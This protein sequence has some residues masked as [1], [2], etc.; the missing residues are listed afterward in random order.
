MNTAARIRLITAILLLTLSAAFVPSHARAAAYS[1]SAT[2][3]VFK[4]GNLI[5]P[6]AG[7]ENPD[8]F[9]F[10][11][12]DSRLDLKPLNWE[13]V[14]PL[15]PKTV[16][17]DVWERWSNPATGRDPGRP[18]TLGQNVT[19]NMAAYWEVNLS[20][21]S[22]EEL[23][24]YDLLFISHRQDFGFTA[25]DRE[26]LRKLVDAGGIVWIE[27]SG[28][29]R[30]VAGGEFFLPQLQ[31]AGTA[32]GAP[33]GPVVNAPHHP[34]LNTPYR[35][36]YDEIAS[37][38]DKNYG[39][40]HIHS[41]FNAN[42]PPDPSVLINIVGNSAAG[43]LPYI[44]GGSY[45]SGAV[46]A[47]SS[48]SGSDI[49]DYAG[50]TNPRGVGG[51]SGAYSGPN[52][53]AA[54]SED[55]KFVYNLVAW[56][57]A[58]N[59]ERRNARR[60]ASSFDAVGAPLVERFTF[61]SP[62]VPP[63][64]RVVSPSA[65]LIVKEVAFVT[66]VVA[67]K[68]V[69][70]AYD[71]QPSRDLDNDGNPDEGVPDLA[72]G[73]PYDEIWRAELTSKSPGGS[74]YP[75]APSF[76]TLGTAEG[77]DE[78]VFVT[79]D[80]G[81][82]VAFRAFPNNNGILLP[83]NALAYTNPPSGG[84]G[85][86]Y[87]QSIAPSPVFYEGRIYVSQPDGIVR[88]VEASTGKTLH[89]T[90]ET[91]QPYAVTGSP[92]VGFTRYQPPLAGPRS[93]GAANNAL[94]LVLY[95]P[96]R[97]TG[98]GSG[99]RI[100]PFWLGVRNEIVTQQ[101]G[102]GIYNTRAMGQGGPHKY[103]V[104]NAVAGSPDSPTFTNPKV[105]IYDNLPAFLAGAE[106][107]FFQPTDP[108]NP[109]SE[110][111]Q[112]TVARKPGSTGP[113]PSNIIVTADYDVM[114]ISA[115][116][117]PGITGSGARPSNEVLQTRGEGIGGA[118]LSTL[119]LSPEDLLLYAAAEKVTGASEYL[120]SIY[121]TN[122]QAI[123]GG[124]KTLWRFTL[125]AGYGF[126]PTVQVN[127]TNVADAPVLTNALRFSVNWPRIDQAETINDPAKTEVL[128][129]VVPAGAPIVTNDGITYVLAN[130]RPE[131]FD[132]SA[133]PNGPSVAVLMAFKT[134]NEVV[135]N[136]GAMAPGTP[137]TVTQADLLNPGSTVTLAQGTQ[138]VVD[139][140]RGK[141]RITS[142]QPTDRVGPAASAS[143]SFVVSATLAGQTAPVVQVHRPLYQGGGV[144]YGDDYT[145]LLWYYVLPG[146]V[147]PGSSPTLYGDHIFFLGRMGTNPSVPSSV[148]A[149][150]A[151]PSSN[152]PA[153]QRARQVSAVVATLDNK[154]QALNH[155]R[156]VRSLGVN[157]VALTGTQGALLVNS[158]QGPLAFEDAITLIAD[159]KRVVEAK[160]DGSAAW[161]L[162]STV[163]YT[164]AGGET[165]I[166]LGNGIANPP[167][168]GRIVE[169]RRSIS[170]PSTV[171][172]LSASDL[173]IADTGNNRVVRVDRGGKVLWELERINDS[174]NILA[175]GDPI[176]LNGPTDVHFWTVYSYNGGVISGYEAHYLV[177]DAGNFRLVE[178]VDYYDQQGNIIADVNP[179]VPGN[180]PG[181]RVLVWTTR[182]HSKEG[183]RLRFQSV[184]RFLAP[185]QDP[186]G[187]VYGVPYIVA[188]V[189]NLRATG[190]DSTATSDFTGGALVQVTYK[191]YNTRFLLKDAN[192]N[193]IGP[194][195][196]WQPGTPA[197]AT[198]PADN[199]LI[200]AAVDDLILPDNSVK[201]ITRPLYF[202]Q[203]TLP[204]GTAQGKK[205]YLLCDADGV[206]LIEPRQVNGK[207]LRF[208]T[209]AFTQE[210]YNLIN[211]VDSGGNVR[212][213][214]ADPDLGF[215]N[216][217]RLQFPQA[218]VD[219]NTLPRFL[220]SSVRRL[221]SGNY[222]ITN[223]FTG[224]SPLFGGAMA[225]NSPPQAG[226]QFLGEVLEIKPT[227]N[228]GGTFAEFSV[229]KIVRE[230]IT[231]RDSM[232][233]SNP[234]GVRNRQQMGDI[235]NT[236][237]LEQPLFA[238]R[239]Y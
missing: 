185:R 125:H 70:R 14:N 160:P 16:T 172:R 215:V 86:T 37:L 190:A 219:P 135:L 143:Q 10:Y 237:I 142:F 233:N 224:S 141:I 231:V 217:G 83:T 95:Q 208:V 161:T 49:N 145:P 236:G 18:Y 200:A 138:F 29:M 197:T 211:G 144:N 115:K 133:S 195:V 189:G 50:G 218:T 130:A 23:L 216:D 67:G 92:T 146:R 39:N 100:L 74:V 235:S 228:K 52:L 180:Q 196:P 17:P 55:L 11:F 121:A 34:L 204:D 230:T 179:T 91:S 192:G 22:I 110:V 73:A 209:W 26:K 166:F 109:I 186:G 212:N 75:S 123:L 105:R 191:P 167:A 174:F 33:G 19:K 176:T 20:R 90:A 187:T 207:V 227:G 147:D 15:A 64:S 140:A 5:I 127:G 220:P 81:S 178:V 201:R 136:I 124:T 30:I 103:R 184:E 175:S 97:D 66:G 3:R 72:Q 210:D 111:G 88:C 79:L 203:I 182:M 63:A 62:L 12:A 199:G 69:L 213:F 102:N 78:A 32:P 223:S 71:M 152:D 234:V 202:Q 53:Q 158:D 47:T 118:G 84:S 225:F 59:T 48:G 38:G 165:P 51:N 58:S 131:A 232:G 42:Q 76:A 134:N 7:F 8:P 44:A 120:T 238:D 43:G 60:T 162:D 82:L 93:A 198:E 21:A 98:S 153:V 35:L 173:M 89:W 1:Y 148:I 132:G 4:V 114:Y 154:K 25:E 13:F 6:S 113:I 151:D 87:S 159:G 157:A 99:G 214:R 229:P 101:G 28:G 9:V 164:T 27:N 112:I 56:S 169:E 54:R 139:A 188:V 150:D 68:P 80:D 126:N 96:V 45:G 24:Q 104:A 65:P 222:L 46:I 31:F 183:R 94:D 239:L 41:R 108:N 177:A 77:V 205:A 119:A 171:R 122:E 163:K 85:G 221:G 36:T 137:V 129:D 57:G 181:E 206:Y 168:A 149:V 156:W 117:N 194:E 193:V 2:R 155:V 128:R 107:G 226:G 116:G 170:R 106:S 61:L 40:Y